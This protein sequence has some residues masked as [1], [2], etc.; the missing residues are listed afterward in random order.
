MESFKMGDPRKIILSLSAVPL[1][2]RLYT[3]IHCIV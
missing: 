2:T 3:P 1:D